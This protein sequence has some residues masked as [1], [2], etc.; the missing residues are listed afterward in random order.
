MAE[1]PYRVQA[2]NS[3]TH[4]ENRMHDDAVAQKYGF[5]GGLVP[6]VDVFAYMVHVPV[7]KWGRAFLERGLMEVRFAKPVYDGE[8]VVVT[9]EPSDEGLAIALNGSDVRAAGSAS[10]PDAP[11]PISVGDYPET[12]PVA[13]RGPVDLRSYQVGKWL[14]TAPR[15]WPGQSGAD[16]RAEVRETDPIYAR[17]G[18]VHPG[19]VQ[20]V[21]NRVLME[22]ALLGPW[23]H[24]GSRMQ[25]LSTAACDE[26]LV[27]RARVTANYEK[28]G[29]RFVEVD[30]VVVANGR[31]LIAHCQHIA[32][33]QLRERAA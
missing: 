25:M 21:M 4:S 24:L 26:E 28:K 14:G 8:T 20:R 16:Y 9:S 10:L 11:P 13:V 1:P 12:A 30:A 5:S 6:G 23:I 17:E 27:A 2:F 32:I 29:N 3:A 7:A 22:N 31:K 19:M 15:S 18:L 33:Y